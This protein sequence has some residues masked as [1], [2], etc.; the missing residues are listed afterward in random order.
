MDSRAEPGQFAFEPADNA[1]EI[2]P[3]ARFGGEHDL[4]TKLAGRLE[5]SDLMPARRRDTS[6]FEPRGAAPGN[7]DPAAL[8]LASDDCLRER[9]LPSRGHV[10]DADRVLAEED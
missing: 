2:P 10:V 8:T 5:E 7:H 3:P 6:R 1:D 9:E 4:S